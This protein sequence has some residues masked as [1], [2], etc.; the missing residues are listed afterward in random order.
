MFQARMENAVAE[1]PAQRDYL[2]YSAVSLYRQCPLRYFFRYVAGLPEQTVSASLVFGGAIHAAVQF[3]FE[4]L[5][6]GNS[7]PDLAALRDVYLDPGEKSA[8]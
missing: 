6:A 3:H 5:L 1:K 4:E 8:E 7:A 2:S